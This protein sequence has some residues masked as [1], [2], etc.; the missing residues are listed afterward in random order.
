MGKTII[1]IKLGMN[2]SQNGEKVLLID[3]S[4]G[5]KKISEYLNVNQ[6]IIYDVK[7]VLDTTCSLDQA[8]IEIKDGLSLL[9][10]PRMA[11]KL[12]NIKTES[13]SKLIN[14]AKNAYD[15][16]IID[17]DKISLSFINFDL[18]SSIVTDNN[19][20]FSCIKE[21]NGDKH[22]AQKFNVQNIIALLNKYN[23]KGVK[24]GTMMSAK[25]IKKMTYMNMEAIIEENNN[26]LNVDLDFM[27]NRDENSFNKAVN[28]VINK[29]L[30]Y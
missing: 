30:G 8:V 27:L 4:S 6:D 2:F 16:I 18:I 11:D 5:K 29:M 1:C 14:E 25:D 17:I 15:I 13:F 7:D 12:D 19:N 26:Y 3:L 10:Y 23:K 22:I 20:N 9:P 24:K 28:L 21:F